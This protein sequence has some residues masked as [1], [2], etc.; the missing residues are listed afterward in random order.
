MTTSA[1][2]LSF[3]LAMTLSSFGQEAVRP[4]VATEFGVPVTIQA[5]FI[6]KENSYYAQN[7]VPEPFALEVSAVN[8]VKLEKTVTIEYKFRATEEGRKHIEKTG[9]T[10]SLEAYESVYE[11]PFGG[12]WL[13]KG[14][15]GHNFALINRLYI[16]PI[17][18]DAPLKQR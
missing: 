4:R 13:K 10:V 7:M 1:I 17:Q 9:T 15:Q 3:G 2:T 5:E 12:P 18:K 11:S 16:R 6:E 14:E 8:G